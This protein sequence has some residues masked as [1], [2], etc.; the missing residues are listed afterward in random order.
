METIGRYDVPEVNSV[1]EAARPTIAVGNITRKR[2]VELVKLAMETVAWLEE[3][4]LK[5]GEQCVFRQI[6]ET[7]WFSPKETND[8]VR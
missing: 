1:R 2:Y 5:Q 8:A 3:K 4:G 7:L 6:G